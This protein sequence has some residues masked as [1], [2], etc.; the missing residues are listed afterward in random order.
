MGN[1]KSHHML[2]VISFSFL[3]L[4]LWALLRYEKIICM[5][6]ITLRNAKPFCCKVSEEVPGVSLGGMGD[7]LREEAESTLRRGLCC[8]PRCSLVRSFRRTRQVS[9]GQIPLEKG[10]SSLHQRWFF[11]FCGSVHK[12]PE[13]YSCLCVKNTSQR[14]SEGIHSKRLTLFSIIV[15]YIEVG[16]DQ[17]KVV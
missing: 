12:S 15:S 8:R 9:V 17:C 11:W 2:F 13:I 3:S 5:Q 6:L 4:R 1:M 14:R 10:N 7:K 16:L